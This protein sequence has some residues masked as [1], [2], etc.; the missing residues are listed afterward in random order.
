MYLRLLLFTIAFFLGSS[1]VYGQ[2]G[3]TIPG[4]SIPAWDSI[5]NGTQGETQ[6][7]TGHD[8]TAPGD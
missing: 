1:T 2:L 8:P 5:G 3:G 4:H 6:D 7:P